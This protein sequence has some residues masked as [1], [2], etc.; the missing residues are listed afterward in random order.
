MNIEAEVMKAYADCNGNEP[1]EVTQHIRNL[2]FLASAPVSRDEAIRIMAKAIANGYNEFEAV[3]LNLL[4]IESKVTI[5]REASVCI[6]VAPPV[7]EIPEMM[8]DEWHHAQEN[9]ATR[10][11]WD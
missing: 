4:P 8:A 10:I 7:K 1:F 9:G 2:S 11:W 6:Y 5:A 3:L